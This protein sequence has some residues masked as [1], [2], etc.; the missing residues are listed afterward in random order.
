MTRP[1]IIHK[2][3]VKQ[4]KTPLAEKELYLL[5]YLEGKDMH[6]LLTLPKDSTTRKYGELATLSEEALLDLLHQWI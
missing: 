2:L 6:S 4:N 5:A 1:K 3:R